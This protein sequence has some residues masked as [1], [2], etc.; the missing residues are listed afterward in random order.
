[1]TDS[2]EYKIEVVVGEFEADATITVCVIDRPSA[3]RKL[4]VTDVIG[5]SVSLTWE[6]PFDEG[7]CDMLGYKVE[8]R[9]K[10]SGT[11]SEIIL[12][13]IYPLMNLELHCI[14]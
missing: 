6:P 4:R 14:L 13:K 8:R 10:R 2:G 1:M 9:D 11:I 3:V 5:N 12:N 7:N